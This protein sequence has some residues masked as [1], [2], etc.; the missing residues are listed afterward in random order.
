MHSDEDKVELRRLTGEDAELVASWMQSD[1]LEQNAPSLARPELKKV[2]TWRAIAQPREGRNIFLI[3]SDGKPVG[4]STICAIQSD[5]GEATV[6][7]VLFESQGKG[8]GFRAK[9]IQHAIAF[10]DLGFQALRSRVLV[11]NTRVQRGLR[12]LGYTDHAHQ[13][14]KD[15]LNFRLERAGK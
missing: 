5:K 13:N 15:V 14:S 3:I 7:T 2:E 10:N 8:I 11:G 12:Y 9:K 1:R 4:L 6:G